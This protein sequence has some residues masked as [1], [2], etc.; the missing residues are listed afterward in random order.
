MS[1]HDGHDHDNTKTA[2][3]K[4]RRNNAK[5]ADEAAKEKN[6]TRGKP[7]PSTARKVTEP[8][9]TAKPHEY[10]EDMERPG[11]CY[12]CQLKRDAS[13]HYRAPADCPHD[14]VRREFHTNEHSGDRKAHYVC[15]G[16]GKTSVTA[17]G[18][19]KKRRK[20]A[21][22]GGPGSLSS[23]GGNHGAQ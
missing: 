7:K 3:A 4:C 15:D 2:R 11:R 14:R 5:P 22:E 13:N 21:S 1:A 20:T 19:A 12:V 10:D 17:F 16:C 18:N 6:A 8:I 9:H 23:P